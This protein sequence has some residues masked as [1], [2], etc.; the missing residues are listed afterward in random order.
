MHNS[1]KGPR[2]SAL[3]AKRKVV[4]AHQGKRS[5]GHAI[6]SRSKT[7]TD[8]PAPGANG[9]AITAGPLR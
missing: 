9:P 5:V 6:G 4:T 1:K 7:I 2:Q 8:Q 3:V